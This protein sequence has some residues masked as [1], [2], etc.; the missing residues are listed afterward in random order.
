MTHY[1]ETPAQRRAR[2]AYRRRL[3]ERGM[4][5]LTIYVPESHREHFIELARQAR[6]S[7]KRIQPPN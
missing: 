4:V 3:G 1:V 2:E 7:W 6:E 5:R